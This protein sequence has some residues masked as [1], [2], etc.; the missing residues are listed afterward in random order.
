VNAA[1]HQHHRHCLL[2]SLLRRQRPGARR[3]QS[4]HRPPFRGSAELEAA[5]GIAEFPGE[6]SAQP[7]HFLVAPGLAKAGLFRERDES[8]VAGARAGGQ[9][10]GKCADRRRTGAGQHTDQELGSK[11]GRLFHP[12]IIA[13]GLMPVLV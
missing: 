8:R 3:G 9:C 1:L 5:H 13:R 7:L 11:A 12:R 10:V 2:V 6:R 4:K